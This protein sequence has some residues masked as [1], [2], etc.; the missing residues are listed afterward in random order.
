MSD[1]DTPPSQDEDR[2]GIG[3]AYEIRKKARQEVVRL[4]QP[5]LDELT[6]RRAELEQKLSVRGQARKDVRRLEQ[7]KTV[8]DGVWYELSHSVKQLKKSEGDIDF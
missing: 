3:E 2:L 7:R 1:H 6:K 5:A 8:L 4:L